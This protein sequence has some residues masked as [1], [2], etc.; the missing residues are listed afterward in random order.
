MI[1]TD[2]TGSSGGDAAQVFSLLAVVADPDA[3][4]AKLKKLVAATEEH[5]KFVALVGPADQIAA[6]RVE[7]TADRA[8]AAQ[9]LSAAITEAKRLKDEGKS[10][11]KS[12]TDAATKALE[13][14]K[15]K[16]AQVRAEIQ[17]ELIAAKAATSALAEQ[18]AAA[19]AAEKDAKD[20]VAALAKL[21]AETKAERDAAMAERK[22]LTAKIEAF[23]KG[24]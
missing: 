14:A 12:L 13:D 21:Q 4:G 24:L 10:A 19:A 16:A 15:A 22:A 9:E 20:R 23:A 5:K 17:Q 7:A 6:L 1:S 11:A 8:A 2:I 18:V 3:Y